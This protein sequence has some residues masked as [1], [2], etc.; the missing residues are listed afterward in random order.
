MVDRHRPPWPAIDLTIPDPDRVD[1][2]LLVC[3]HEGGILGLVEFSPHSWRAFYQDASTRDRNARAL[4]AIAG[5]GVAIRSLDVPDE[6]WA[7]R[8]QAS[9]RAVTVGRVTIA[10]PWDVPADRTIDDR[11]VVIEPSTGFGTGHHA[12]TRLCILALQDLDLTDR[13]LLDLG[14]GSGVL[15]IAAITLG[16]TFAVG[17]DW[18]RDAIRAAQENVARNHMTGRVGLA[19]ADLRSVA[20]GCFD[21]VVANLTGS[22]V[23]QA[24]RHITDLLVRP[25]GRAIVSGFTT[26]DEPDV[27]AALSAVGV[28]L[29][30]RIDDDW[31]SLTIRGPALR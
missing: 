27:H 15:A 10:P 31:V 14:T 4:A 26:H 5:G 3:L 28:V 17:L 11:I 13:R 1:A 25:D 6:A 7:E 19:C 21:V 18:D 12:S 20:D 23:V 9:L 22:L 2:D 29:A 24:A 8:S 16:A 30:R